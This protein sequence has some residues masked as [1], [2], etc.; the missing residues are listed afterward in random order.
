MG[1]IRAVLCFP[2]ACCA[3]CVREHQDKREERGEKIK[4]NTKTVETTPPAPQPPM[5]GDATLPP[6]QWPDDW[7]HPQ[8]NEP[9]EKDEGN[10]ELE[11]EKKTR[12]KIADGFVDGVDKL[13][14]VP[15]N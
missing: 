14:K 5:Q 3:Y 1:P 8:G 15:F 9:K 10:T 4:D 7:H 11:G 13:S 12:D 6:S 2:F